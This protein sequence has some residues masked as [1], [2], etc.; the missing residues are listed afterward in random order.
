VSDAS[1]GWRVVAASVQGVAHRRDGTPCQDAHTHLCLPGGALLAAVADGAGSAALSEVGARVAVRA[2]T[3]AVRVRWNG[4]VPDPD[5]VT[6][7][8]RAAVQ[9]AG[10]AVEREAAGRG[11]D[12]RDLAT[13]LI[14]LLATAER[15][16]VARIGD[17]AAVMR[18]PEGT[19]HTLSA[20]GTGEYVNETV[21]LTSPAVADSLQLDIR[22][23]RAGAIALLTDGLEHLALQRR[24]GVPHP[25][26]WEPLFRFAVE[27]EP[28]EAD[29][30]LAAFL[31]GPRVTSSATDDLTLLLGVPR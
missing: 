27:A 11:A 24:G 31:G 28:A 13:T 9:E 20:G 14:V 22:A 26:F 5:E 12:A 2:A 17:G 30:W 19:W 18:D 4:G 15:V 16:A 7:L 29:A 21:F 1:G 23:I 25:A 10:S 8:L 6:R 3:D